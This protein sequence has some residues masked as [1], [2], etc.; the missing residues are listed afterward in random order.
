M[1]RSE[2]GAFP[3][4]DEL[5]RPH[6]LVVVCERF[7]HAHDDDVGDFAEFSGEKILGDNFV[8]GERSY[9]A[10]RAARAES[11]PHRAA[12]LCG[13]TLGKSARGGYENRLDGVA[14]VESD[15]EFRR[16]VLGPG[17]VEN[18]GAGQREFRFKRFAEILGQG[19]RFV[20]VIDIVPVQRLQNLVG[21]ERS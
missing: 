19:R 2:I 18:R 12:D 14:V 20:P 7:S 17:R 6:R 9:D 16:S 13:D 8:G 4:V 10:A 1:P 5:Q 21:A 3:R 15:K 11:A